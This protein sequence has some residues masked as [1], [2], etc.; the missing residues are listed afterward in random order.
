MVTGSVLPSATFEQ[1]R[2]LDTCTVSNA[3]ERLKVRPRNEGSVSGSALRC[4]FPNLPPVLGCRARQSRQDHHSRY[5]LGSANATYAPLIF[6][7][8]DDV[9]PG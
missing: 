8:V 5:G 1:I 9:S 7:F 6:S 2:K 3:I 4:I